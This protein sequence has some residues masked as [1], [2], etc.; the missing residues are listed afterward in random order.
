[1]MRR[2][3]F[4]LCTLALACTACAGSSATSGPSEPPEVERF[5]C[6]PQRWE[7]PPPNIGETPPVEAPP[8]DSL[9]PFYD[10]ADD[11]G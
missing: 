3:I 4:A 1:M 10:S 2:W 11:E 8:H 5:E 9:Q 7:E 6:V